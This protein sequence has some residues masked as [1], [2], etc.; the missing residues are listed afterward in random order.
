MVQITNNIRCCRECTF[1]HNFDKS[2]QQTASDLSC[3]KGVFKEYHSGGSDEKD[4][5]IRI[6][7]WDT[8]HPNCPFLKK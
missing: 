4:T 5:L 7:A 8:V 6:G 1:Y 3:E 2:Y